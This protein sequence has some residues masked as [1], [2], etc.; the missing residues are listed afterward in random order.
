[1]NLSF[2][3]LACPE[4]NLKT[5]LA[6]AVEYGYDGVDFRGLGP[7]MELWKTPEFSSGILTTAALVL[8][9]GLVVS[10]F[11]SSARLNT[12]TPEET[13]AQLAEVEEYARI[14][15]AFGTEFIRVFVGGLKPGETR[16]GVAPRCADHLA[17]M[18][19]VAARYGTSVVVETHDD[20]VAS[21][22]VLKIL[23]ACPHHA[24]VLWDVHHPYRLA[25]ESPAETWRLLGK[26][27]RYTHIKDSR[28]VPGDPKTWHYCLTGDG[29]IPVREILKLLHANGYDGWLTYE[30]EKRWHADIAPP[31]VAL[32]HYAQVMRQ[33]L[34]ELK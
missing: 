11:S 30:W 24:E 7:E 21:P 5:I 3:T 14:C 15:R 34:A 22:N 29:D 16:E 17:A 13:A 32:P 9:A 26:R 4:W 19:E 23:A 25:D 1:M 27:I 12:A 31:E 18:I 6:R 28:L 2:T 20:W 8:D 33:W 10:G